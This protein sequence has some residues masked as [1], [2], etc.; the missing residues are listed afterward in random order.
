M[1]L[2]DLAKAWNVHTRIGVYNTEAI[3]GLFPKRL[4]LEQEK[5]WAE[6]GCPC[7]EGSGDR[8]SPDEH[9]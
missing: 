8:T 6:H 9:I 7:E 2:M 5:A 4:R 1:R 3:I